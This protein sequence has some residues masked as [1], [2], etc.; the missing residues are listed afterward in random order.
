MTPRQTALR[1]AASPALGAWMDANADRIHRAILGDRRILIDLRYGD[2]GKLKGRLTV[3]DTFYLSKD[4][5]RWVV[6][7]AHRGVLKDG[8]TVPI[9]TA[10]ALAGDDKGSLIQENASPGQYGGIITKM[11][12]TTPVFYGKNAR[13]RY[14]GY[15]KYMMAYGNDDLIV[16]FDSAAD[17]PDEPDAPYPLS[18]TDTPEQADVV[19]RHTVQDGTVALW[20]HSADRGRASDASI[21]HVIRGGGFVRAHV[22]GGGEYR[23]TNSVGLV[24][25]RAPIASM[26]HRLH[27]RGFTVYLDLTTGETAEAIRRK[28]EYLTGRAERTEARGERKGE[29]A[30]RRLIG[31]ET[32]QDRELTHRKI[33]GYFPTPLDLAQRVAALAAIEPGHQVL[34]PSAGHGAL[35]AVILA[36]EPSALVDAIEV[37]GDLRNDLRKRGIPVVAADV[38]D[39]AF[40]PGTLYD[41]IIMNPPFEDGKSIDHVVQA[42]GYLAPGGRLV[43]IV[44]ESIVFRVDRKHTAFREWLTLHSVEIEDTER[45]VF[46]RSGD[47]KTRVLIGD[48]PADAH[49]EPAT[50]ETLA[51]IQSARTDARRVTGQRATTAE[52][53]REHRWERMRALNDAARQGNMTKADRAEQIGLQTAMQAE[54]IAARAEAIQR[55][56]ERVTATTVSKG[57]YGAVKPAKSTAPRRKHVEPVGVLP[58]FKAAMRK[59]K[60][61]T[62]A[63]AVEADTPYGIQHRWQRWIVRWPNRVARLIQIKQ[64]GGYREQEQPPFIWEIGTDY[65]TTVAT[66]QSDVADAAPLFAAMVASLNSDPQIRAARGG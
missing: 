18:D 14:D 26:V 65:S 44:P 35:V 12:F 20:D 36:A 16:P 8:R 50:N 23:R 5:K 43:A 34:E 2:T 33:E 52:S 51:R 28:R 17:K 27:A 7:S 6:V 49:D 47:I 54:R 55:A 38:F 22:S 57:G 62:G 59:I 21:Y 1:V 19:I 60:G 10:V 24:E 4:N 64:S 32:K 63:I 29:E 37:N 30:E 39:P 42:W 25:T 58:D 3:N 41:R 11:Q 45:Q 66:G 56:A 53:V 9:V 46:G 15:A 48:K 13:K 40:K 61:L 31:A